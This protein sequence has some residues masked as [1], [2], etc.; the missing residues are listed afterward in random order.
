[1]TRKNNNQKVTFT[2]DAT[3]DISISMRDV[4]WGNV[5][6]FN[7]G[8]CQSTYRNLVTSHL[9]T[10][11]SEAL[12]WVRNAHIPQWAIGICGSLLSRDVSDI[13]RRITSNHSMLWWFHSCRCSRG[14]ITSAKAAIN[15]ISK[16][17]LQWGFCKDKATTTA[18]FVFTP[19]VPFS[20]NLVPF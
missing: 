1:M 8:N 13:S 14:Q 12:V 16:S 19:F 11:K 7:V 15:L 6:L 5:F 9:L 20:D 17:F 18:I 2:K 10:C 4:Q 3:H